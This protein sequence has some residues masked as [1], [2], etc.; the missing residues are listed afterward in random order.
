MGAQSLQTCDN[1]THNN[2]NYYYYLNLLN[3]IKKIWKFSTR[4]WDLRIE[5]P[6]QFLIEREMQLECKMKEMRINNE[7]GVQISLAWVS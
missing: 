3:Y 6:T 5:P 4:L 7:I 1:M 2:S